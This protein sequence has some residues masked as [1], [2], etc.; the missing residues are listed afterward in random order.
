ML[1]NPAMNLL[2]LGGVLYFLATLRENFSLH[3]AMALGATALLPLALAFGLV[4]ARWIVQVPFLSNVAHI[5][6]TF[7]CV[8]IVLATVLAGVGFRRAFERLGTPAGR[9]DLVVAGLMLFGITFGYIAFTQ[10]VHRSVFGYGTTFTF[11]KAGEALPVKPFIWI[12]LAV[13]LVALA[14]GAATLRRAL[15]LGKFSAATCLVLLTCALALVWR[16]GLHAGSG[17]ET[18]V[19]KPTLRANLHARSDAVQFMRAAVAREPA[20]GLGL[21]GNFF[22]GWTGY[23]GLESIAGPDALI[24]PR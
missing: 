7:S 18:Y 10:A 19:M 9:G 2:L 4:P 20:R 8:L 3:A 6:N 11:M 23:Y 1:F 17:Y 16:N 13:A 22:P 5:D 15:T 24:N 14:L 12:Y 21:Q